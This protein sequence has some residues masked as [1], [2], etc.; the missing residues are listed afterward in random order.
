MLVTFS[1]ESMPGLVRVVDLLLVAGTRVV[2][3]SGS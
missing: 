1:S 3:V 2:L